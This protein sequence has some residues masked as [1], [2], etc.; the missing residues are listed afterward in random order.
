MKLYF[1]EHLLLVISVFIYR[2]VMAYQS[3]V[4][5]DFVIQPRLPLGIITNYLS[6]L[7]YV[8]HHLF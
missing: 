2:L 5:I 1:Y 4:G 8:T 6:R 7:Y 3:L